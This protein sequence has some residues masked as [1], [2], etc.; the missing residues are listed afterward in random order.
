MR[1]ASCF[2]CLLLTLLTAP[3]FA[4]NKDPQFLL[5]EQLA[6]KAFQSQNF[7]QAKVLYQQLY[8]K[9]KQSHHFNQ[10]VE[11][12]FRLGDFDT[13]EKELKSFI[14][15]NP[16]IGKARIDLIYAYMS[17]DK[18]NKADEL[19]NE[20]LKNLPENKNQIVNISNMLRGRLLNDYAIA[21]LEK[22]AK[23][24]TEGD[25]LYMERGNLYQSMIN[26]QQAF[27]YYFLELE[28]HPD[29]YNIV[30]NKLQTL[31]LYD[32]NKSITDEMRI[33][34]LK[35]TQELPDNEQ[36]AQ[37]LMWFALQNEDYD[38]AL[39]QC[40][41]LDRRNNDQDVHIINLAQ[42]CLDNGQYE[43]AKEAFDHIINKGKIN[44]YYGNAVIGTIKT[45]N[46]LFKLN[47]KTE[48]RNYE[49]LSQ[50]IQ[51]AYTDVGTKE[52]PDLVEI[53]ADIMAYHL[54]Q[55]E[56][57]ISLLQQAINQVN[58]KIQQC[59]LKLKLADIYLYNDEVWEATLLYSQVDKSMKEEP[60]GH[61]ARFRNAQLRYFIGEFTWAQTQ[62]NVLKAATSKLIANDAMS[63]SLI[64]GDNLENDTTGV[65]LRRLSRA[66]FKIYQHKPNEALPVLDSICIDGNE[67]SKPHALYRI[68]EIKEKEQDYLFADSLY[69]QIVSN[70]PDSYMADDAL[71]HAALLEHHQLKDKEAAKQHYELLI[72]QYPTSLYTAQAKK[73]YRKL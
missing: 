24:N 28:V 13:A 50:K 5:D 2:L 9:K 69:L 46:Q 31:L 56:Q 60:L 10:Y 4:Q 17:N 37:L 20:I 57:A 36:F 35:K 11:C 6:G 66:D 64:I 68:A 27:E 16:T 30:K 71:M 49:R 61:E 51:D 29:Q 73:N 40:K 58:N 21:V 23:V 1:N 33:A 52:Y 70:F 44:P 15:K 65:E 18:K 39:A 25:P 19:F 55:S 48:V 3:I 41:S 14:K 34:L 59:Q 38:I 45:E 22:G 7:E 42:I 54:N 8:E 26:Y 12:L 62:L 67:I 63:L 72:D 53:Q 47:P 43:L 32:V